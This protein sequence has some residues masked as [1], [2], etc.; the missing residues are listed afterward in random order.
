MS[1]SAFWVYQFVAECIAVTWV[2]TT[3]IHLGYAFYPLTRHQTLIWRTALGS[4]VL[5]DL[6]AIAELS[7]YC[8]GVWGSGS[9]SAEV[10]ELWIYWVRQMVKVLTCAITIAYLFV[11]IGLLPHAL[12]ISS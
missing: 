7:Y 9:L 12:A 8:Y 3:I 6:V 1:L 10:P 5:Y 11:S 4:V 2:I